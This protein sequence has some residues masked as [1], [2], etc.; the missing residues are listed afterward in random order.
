MRSQVSPADALPRGPPSPESLLSPVLL[1]ARADTGALAEVAKQWAAA[2]A[3]SPPR[4]A[5]FSCSTV[6]EGGRE[7]E[8]TFRADSKHAD[9]VS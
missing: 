5:L 2:S 7:G 6:A 8:P 4:T 3:R 1:G 9:V